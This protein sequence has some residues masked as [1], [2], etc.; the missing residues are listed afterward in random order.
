MREQK[1]AIGNRSLRIG[2]LFLAALFLAACASAGVVDLDSAGNHTVVVNEGDLY[3]LGKNT[4]EVDFYARRP[5]LRFQPILSPDGNALVYVDQSH[6]L[7][8]QPFDGS[9]STVLLKLIGVPGPGTVVFLPSNELF[10]LDASLNAD[11]ERVVKIINAETGLDTQPAI[12]GIGQ[13]YVTANAVKTKNGATPSEGRLEASTPG[14]FRAVFQAR[15]CL[16]TEQTC[17]YLYS[18]E[19]DGF[20]FVAQLPRRLE[21]SLL[22]LL[23][24]RPTDDVTGALLTADGQHLVLRVRDGDPIGSRFSLYAIDLTNNNAPEILVKDAAQRPDYAVA[25]DGN[26]VAYED[27]SGNVSTIQLYNFDTNQKT[28]VGTGA[29]DPQWW[30]K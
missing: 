29:V 27:V 7:M 21:T 14:Q 8:R 26:W 3:V 24:R 16:I 22:L 30:G 18:A 15:T 4:T 2:P 6:Q 1:S 12:Q 13:V 20:K 11:G 28:T 10:I 9:A 23:A 19:A 25:P 17:M 5:D